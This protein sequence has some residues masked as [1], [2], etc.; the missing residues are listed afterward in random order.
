[1]KTEKQIYNKIKNDFDYFGEDELLDLSKK[2]YKIQSI[3]KLNYNKESDYE[4]GW[5]IYEDLFPEAFLSDDDCYDANGEIIKT[6]LRDYYL[7]FLLEY[8]DGSF[9]IIEEQDFGIDFND[10]VSKTE[11]YIQE[12][13]EE[14][15]N[16]KFVKVYQI[17]DLT[18]EKEIK[19]KQIETIN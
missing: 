13:K 9:E 16:L 5:E 12:I 19:I 18:A 2:L 15:N 6:K 8:N 14:Y 7:D 4:K 3:E 11:L 17:K 10:A 1:M